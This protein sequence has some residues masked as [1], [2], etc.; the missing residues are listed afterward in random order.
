MVQKLEG[1]RIQPLSPPYADEIE[2]KLERAAP[3]WRKD[4]PPLAI[5]RIWATYP[6]LGDAVSQAAVFLLRD[7]QV[8]PRDREIILL[9]ICALAGA[10]YEWGV[11]ACGYSA[12]SGL[13]EEAIQATVSA[14]TDDPLWSDRERLLLRLVDEF[15]ASVDVSDPL[16]A[17]LRGT[18][19][20]SQI[21]ELLF[22]AGFYRFIAF[23]VWATRVPLESWASRFPSRE[24][25]DS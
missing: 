15:E 16:W 9:R 24:P 19:T 25:A 13:S 7:G 3:P 11:H 17:E 12:R 1:P 23:S 2:A 4:T 21:L 5:F 6:K 14:K 22:V 18:W 8:E 10:E 20:E